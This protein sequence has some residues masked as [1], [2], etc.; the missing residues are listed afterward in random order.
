M[1]SKCQRHATLLC[2]YD[3]RTTIHTALVA[4]RQVRALYSH[5]LP[6]QVS[7]WNRLYWR[8]LSY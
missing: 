5:K 1:T 8:R 7:Y 6:L 2:L 4:L 3:G